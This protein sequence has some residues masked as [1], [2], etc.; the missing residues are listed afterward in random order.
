MSKAILWNSPL[1]QFDRPGQTQ[2]LQLCWGGG[3]GR[4]GQTWLFVSV[5]V[6][7]LLQGYCFVL[8]YGNVPQTL[9]AASMLV[10]LIIYEMVHILYLCRV[11]A[12]LQEYPN[13]QFVWK[14][15]STM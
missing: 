7:P 3:G 15:C 4:G 12:F 6:L 11:C 5:C 13:M 9:R 8:P 1:T 14:V 10:D 2:H